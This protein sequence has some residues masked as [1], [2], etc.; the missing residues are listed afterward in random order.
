[1][2]HV[3]IAAEKCVPV[4]LEL[5][6]ESAVFFNLIAIAMQ[7]VHK[8]RIEL[9]ESV[10]VL[11]AGL[12]GIFAMQLARQSGG[13]PVIGVDLD[14]A[15]LKLAKH[16]GA[17]STLLADDAVV[18][19]LQSLLQADGAKV[20]I[21]ATGHPDAVLSAFQLASTKGRVLLLGSLRGETDGVNFYRD[22]HRKGLTI[23]GAHEITRPLVENSPGY[24]KQQDEH[25]IALRLL[26]AGRLHTDHLISH[27]FKAA[28]FP[29]AYEILASWDTSVMGMMIHWD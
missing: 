29:K 21:E 8:A 19:N 9:G 26:A 10:L 17:D 3:V 22:V 5:K 16:G 28:E 13:L 6:D 11:G 27:H 4:P 14:T 7:A 1:M 25:N 23:I 12:I 24:W 2:S 15:R 20:V 18:S